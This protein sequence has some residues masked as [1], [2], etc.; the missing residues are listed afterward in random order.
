MV[1]QRFTSL[2]RAPA[3][4]WTT[5]LHERFVVALRKAGGIDNAK[6]KVREICRT[7]PQAVPLRVGSWATLASDA[8]CAVGLRYFMDTMDANCELNI[9]WLCCRHRLLFLSPSQAVLDAM[10][11]EGITV[12]QVKSHLQK[13]RKRQARGGWNG[14]VRDP[15]TLCFLTACVISCF[16]RTPRCEQVPEEKTAARLAF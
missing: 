7:T 4:R 6:P 15:V 11:V 5:E 13:Y 14:G 3:M 2:G 10:R 16:R 9:I 1:V 8:M 12:K